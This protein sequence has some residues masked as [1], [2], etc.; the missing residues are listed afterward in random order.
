MTTRDLVLA[1]T[2]AALIVALGAVPAVPLAFIPVPITLQSLGV[3][4]AGA[5][6]GPWRGALAP[7]LVV[8]LVIIGL[9]V[10]AGG[11]GGLVVLTGPTAGY[12]LGW[13][14]GAFVTGL[15]AQRAAARTGWLP[16]AERLAG[17]ILGGIVVVHVLGIVWLASVT[18]LPIGKAAWGSLAFLP[19]DLL[20]AGLAAWVATS[21]GRVRVLAPR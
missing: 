17:C 15:L 9:P 3:M 2:F 4:L 19:G 7:A 1:A 14:P 6:L 8:L 20:K 21:L 10:L 12:L 11:R 5:V 18:G 16:F 13:I